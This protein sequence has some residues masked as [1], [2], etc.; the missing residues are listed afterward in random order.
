MTLLND[1]KGNAPKR[2]AV[3]VAVFAAVGF[4]GFLVERHSN[5]AVAREVAARV[6]AQCPVLFGGDGG[7]GGWGP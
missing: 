1:Y 3:W 4:V 7:M 6:A 2:A 5:Q